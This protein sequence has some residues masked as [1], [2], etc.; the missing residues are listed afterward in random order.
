VNHI[1]F[2]MMRVL[3]RAYF[4]KTAAR[5]IQKRYSSRRYYGLIGSKVEYTDIAGTRFDPVV[6]T[7]DMFPQY[8][9]RAEHVQFVD[10]YFD[11]LDAT[12]PVGDVVSNPR[13]ANEFYMLAR[14]PFTQSSIYGTPGGITAYSAMLAQS[15]IDKYNLEFFTNSGIPQYA[16]I[17][18]GFV[19]SSGS[20]GQYAGAETG[21]NPTLVASERM[22]LEAAIREYFT[23][24]LSKG[25]RSM[26]VLTLSGTAKVRFEKL[27]VDELEASFATYED[28]NTDRIRMAHRM[29]GPAMGIYETA[30]LGGG[31]DTAAMKRYRDHI[32][33]PG[34]RQLASVVNMLLRA[35]LMIPYFEFAFTPM[36]LEEEE[37]VRKFKLNEFEKGAITLDQ[38]LESTGRQPLPD[39]RGDVRIIRSKNVTFM[40]TDLTNPNAVDASVQNAI[41]QEKGLREL[42]VDAEEDTTE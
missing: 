23:K 29:P 21:D 4:T 13:A 42:F 32:V 15:K 33:V 17:F 14:P 19:D 28:R 10:Q 38:Y 31:R 30:N 1:P 37:T 36:D 22:Q 9:K 27:S 40:Y 39:D 5:F 7:P 16:V 6:A 18:E 3:D 2:H 11:V 41:Q 34:Q 25:N 8:D 20:E 35:G 12:K 24:Q 26:L